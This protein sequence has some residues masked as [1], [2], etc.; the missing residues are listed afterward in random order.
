MASAL[1][2]FEK[3]NVHIITADGRNIVGVLSGYDQLQNIILS[4]A[5]E[6]VFSPVSK[7]EVV[8]LGLYVIR[9]DNVAVVACMNCKK[10]GDDD[11]DDH[12]GDEEYVED[13][14]WKD[15]M[16][17]PIRSIYHERL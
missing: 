4:Q 17:G 14:G 8:P 1:S 16:C 6:R 11:D 7:P 9:G 10:K 2:E 12:E 5:S 15:V 13:E 3:K